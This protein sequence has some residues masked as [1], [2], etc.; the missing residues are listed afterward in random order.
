GVG[1]DVDEEGRRIVIGDRNHLAQ[2][3]VDL[4]TGFSLAKSLDHEEELDD[5]SRIERRVAVVIGPER[6][7]WLREI[8][9][10]QGEIV[11]GETGEVSERR[12]RGARD[13]CP[14]LGIDRDGFE[15]AEVAADDCW[16]K[17]K[18]NNKETWD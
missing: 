13:L 11:G 10:A 4:R 16:R 12:F 14:Q 15:F 3:P 6:S 5:G 2:S 18:N 9:N 1:E 17:K 7:V 8:D